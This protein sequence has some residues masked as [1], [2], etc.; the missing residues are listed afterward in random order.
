MTWPLRL[1]LIAAIT[2]GTLLG[3]AAAPATSPQPA[4]AI[5]P[6]CALDDHLEGHERCR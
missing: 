6:G 1:A 4:P 2:I 5:D 3:G